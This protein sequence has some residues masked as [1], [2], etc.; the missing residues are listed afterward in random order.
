MRASERKPSYSGPRLSITQLAGK[1]A[2]V[3]A[4]QLRGNVQCPTLIYRKGHI[5][6]TH[7]RRGM[8]ICTRSQDGFQTLPLSQT[9]L[10]PRAFQV[11]SSR[12]RTGHKGRA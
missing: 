11:W 3:V 10:S 5:E 8:N 4:R 6:V 1:L 7:P 12:E 2:D 9:P